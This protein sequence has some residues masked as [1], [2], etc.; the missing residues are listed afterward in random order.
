VTSGEG[1]VMTNFNHSESNG[2]QSGKGDFGMFARGFSRALA[3]IY[4]G[5]GTTFFDQLVAEGKLPAPIKIGARRV[6]DR[7]DLDTAFEAFKETEI[8]TTKNSWDD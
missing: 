3:A 5:I 8:E 1:E 2:R 7:Y 6:W 4:I